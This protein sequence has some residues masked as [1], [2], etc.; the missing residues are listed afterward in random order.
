[1]EEAEFNDAREDLAVLEQD[2]EEVVA[3]ENAQ[4][5]EDVY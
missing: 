3:S 5:D 1:M 4:E 2:Y